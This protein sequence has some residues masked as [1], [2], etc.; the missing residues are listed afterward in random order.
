MFKFQN[1]SDY[2][3]DRIASVTDMLNNL[4]WDSLELRGKRDVT[5]P[6]TTPTSYFKK[7]HEDLIREKLGAYKPGQ[8]HPSKEGFKEK[9]IRFFKDF[10]FLKV[11][12]V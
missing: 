7:G 2:D 10:F 5:R 4:G 8:Y 6:G 11:I 12:N 1:F 9:M 3:Y